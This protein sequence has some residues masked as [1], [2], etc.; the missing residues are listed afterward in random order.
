[1]SISSSQD[2]YTFQRDC[3]VERKMKECTQPEQDILDHYFEIKRHGEDKFILPESRIDN[4]EYDLRTTD[5]ILEKTRNSDQYAQSLYAALCNNDFMRTAVIPILKNKQWYCS[6]RY[7]GGIVADMR[8]SGDYIDWYCSGS[9]RDLEVVS[10]GMVTDEIRKDLKL[11]G[12]IVVSKNV[13]LD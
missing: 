8:Q 6:W 9:W 4:L 12:W 7:A 2:R 5:W 11:L 10:E 3:Y 1:M 13:I